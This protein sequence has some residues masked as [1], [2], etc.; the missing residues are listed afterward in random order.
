M[1]I[2]RSYP[3]RRTRT[4]EEI[5]KF[6]W[7]MS[8]Q[9]GTKIFPV[10]LRDRQNEWWEHIYDLFEFAGIRADDSWEPSPLT[11][12]TSDYA[13]EGRHWAVSWMNYAR[14]YEFVGITG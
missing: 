3:L 7:W 8:P 11:L 12:K 14:P 9:H 13:A 10:G 1:K 5:S 6:A 2:K 4:V